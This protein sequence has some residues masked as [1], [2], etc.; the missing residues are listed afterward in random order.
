MIDLVSAFCAGGL[1][2]CLV[3]YFM[4]LFGSPPD[5]P[6]TQ[7]PNDHLPEISEEL[8]TNWQSLE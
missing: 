1:A 2:I 6:E 8:R 4:E 3:Y 7:P 5:G